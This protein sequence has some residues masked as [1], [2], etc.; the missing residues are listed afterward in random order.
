MKS[1][2]SV[3]YFRFCTKFFVFAGFQIW[4][5]VSR[6]WS[7]H[8]PNEPWTF[9][10]GAA[11]Q[12]G[13]R[14]APHFLTWLWKKFQEQ[15]GWGPRL[16][17]GNSLDTPYGILHQLALQNNTT[18]WHHCY[19]IASSYVKFENRIITSLLSYKLA[20][21]DTYMV[22]CGYSYYE[23]P[24]VN[25]N[26]FVCFFPLIFVCLLGFLAFIPI[27]LGNQGGWQLW[28]IFYKEVFLI[29]IC[30]YNPLQ[31]GLSK[32]Y[33]CNYGPGGNLVGDSMYKVT[34]SHKKRIYVSWQPL[35]INSCH[36]YVCFRNIY[37]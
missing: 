23:D 26:F 2:I 13:T 7:L 28:F 15:V 14:Q 25:C 11:F 32:L 8:V 21:A 19:D 16:L 27:L 1:L 4:L 29:Y 35:I 3:K 24:K 33:V 5:E 6:H 37:G 36:Q 30:S 9:H 12:G 31:R 10:T 34:S 18:E 20:W 22:G 17:E